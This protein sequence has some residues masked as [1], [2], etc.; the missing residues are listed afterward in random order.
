MAWITELYQH[1]RARISGLLLRAGTLNLANS[2]HLYQPLT[3]TGEGEEEGQY[4]T[5]GEG[6][7]RLGLGQAE[8]GEAAVGYQQHNL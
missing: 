3:S 2:H 7:V 8:V 4:G 1:T 5:A 6:A